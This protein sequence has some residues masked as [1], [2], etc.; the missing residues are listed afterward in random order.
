MKI[1]IAEE[2]DIPKLN[3]LLRQ[4][5]NVHQ[6][7]RPDLF[8]VNTKK[9][10]SKELEDILKNPLT[11]VFVAEEDE[12]LGYAFCQIL[13]REN[14]SVLTPVK[15]LYIDD[16]CVDEGG[17]GKGVGKALYQYVLIFAKEQNCYNLTLNV[18]AGNDSVLEF[19]KKCG[20]GTQK[21][22]LEKII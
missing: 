1:R 19:Y 20:L 6:A 18:W 3:A 13:K 2:K 16:L 17:R 7:V 10:S 22:T 4:V 14:D 5:L 21:T 9:Y 8:K 11:P 12:V 15:T